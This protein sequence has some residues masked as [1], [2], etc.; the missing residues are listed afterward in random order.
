[1]SQIKGLIK[2]TIVFVLTG[3]FV[4][5]LQNCRSG[6]QKSGDLPICNPKLKTRIPLA[7]PFDENKVQ[8]SE[9]TLQVLQDGSAEIPLLLVVKTSCILEL[10]NPLYVLGQEVKIPDRLRELSQAAL[11]LTVTGPFEQGQA[12]KDMDQSSC[13]IGMDEAE[14]DAEMDE[15]IPQAEVHGGSV[16]VEKTN[17]PESDRQAHL[18]FL[19]YSKSFEIQDHITEEVV[20]AVLS[21]GIN[22][23]HPDLRNRM[24]GSII[25]GGHGINFTSPGG[26]NRTTDDGGEGTH[27][28]GIIGAQRDNDYGVAGLLGGFVKLM[29][30]KVVGDGRRSRSS[31]GDV[32]N[33]IN[34]AINKRVDVIVLSLEEEKTTV[35]VLTLL[36]IRNAVRAGIFFVLGAGDGG[37]LLSD[38]R[39]RFPISAGSGIGG[40]MTVGSV[41]THDGRFSSFSNH[42]SDYVEIGAPGA[43][44]S[45][46][47]MSK[48]GILSTSVDGRYSRRRGTAMAAAMVASAAGLLI[49]Y[50][51]T[52]DI[53]YSP[54]GIERILVTS[55]SRSVS[56]LKNRIQGGRVL[57]FGV[58]TNGINQIAEC[59]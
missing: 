38:R 18:N 59:E 57:D 31:E 52:N 39:L 36:G 54:A 19:N 2:T 32:F 11:K 7:V 49:G 41:D 35:N 16:L 21:T 43:E 55:G 3:F 47:S 30:V 22:H 46:G 24:W 6:S 34:F 42:S 12:E 45:R 25:G 5:F 14:D 29:A 28:A 20:V 8:L 26:E 10:E 27:I 17:D 40:A 23:N 53:P 1:M 33:G 9:K 58:L 56:D 4:I 37:G 15:E 51:K 44:K 13:L 48:Y 50:F